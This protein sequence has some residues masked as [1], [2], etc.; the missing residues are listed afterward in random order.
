MP[1]SN[2][3]SGRYTRP[4]PD[5]VTTLTRQLDFEFDGSDLVV[6]HGEEEIH[7]TEDSITTMPTLITSDERRT[8]SYSGNGYDASSL[9]SSFAGELVEALNS[10]NLR[11][12]ITNLRD[13]DRGNSAII[14]LERGVFL[15]RS[16]ARSLL[17]AGFAIMA[18]R[19]RDEQVEV[20]VS[21]VELE[22]GMR[23][24]DAEIADVGLTLPMFD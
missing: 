24:V 11:R 16:S 3:Q 20:F 21:P 17:E 7:R 15:Q 12:H 8:E 14:E 13:G 6:T 5:S 22:S 2:Q 18:V 23:I 19:T 10:C 1:N 4:S 9:E